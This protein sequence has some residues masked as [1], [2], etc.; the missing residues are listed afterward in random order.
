MTSFTITTVY[1][2]DELR[3][4]PFSSTYVI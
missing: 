1:G 2:P 3:M 4:I